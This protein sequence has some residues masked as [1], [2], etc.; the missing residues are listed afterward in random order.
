MSPNQSRVQPEASIELEQ[1]QMDLEQSG[2][3]QDLEQVPGVF[4]VAERMLQDVF[5]MLVSS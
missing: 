1:P 2:V 3:F 5:R 4:Q